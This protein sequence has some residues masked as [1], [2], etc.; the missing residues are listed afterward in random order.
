[1]IRFLTAVLLLSLTLSAQCFGSYPTGVTGISG[2]S[3]AC[4]PFVGSPW[5]GPWSTP[6]SGLS[7][8]G[9]NVRLYISQ[10][11]FGTL[12]PTPVV[13]HLDFTYNPGLLPTPLPGGCATVHVA[14]AITYTGMAT[15]DLTGSCQTVATI[16]YPPLPG[17]AGLPIYGQAFT[18]DATGVYNTSNLWVATLQ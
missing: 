11:P 13:F 2:V 5:V 8:G 18:L 1:M 12:G 3:G 15:V 10:I 6:A 14:P 4:S 16:T 7:S 17:L 9:G